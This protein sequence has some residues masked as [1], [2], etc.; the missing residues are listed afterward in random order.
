MAPDSTRDTD[1]TMADGPPTTQDRGPEVDRLLEDSALFGALDPHERRHLFE[2]GVRVAFAPGAVIVE[3]GQPGDSFFLVESG[4]VEVSTRASGSKLVLSRMSRGA[5]FG[6]GTAFS[7]KPRT[8]TVVALGPVEAVRFDDA[9][10][11]AL[12]DR[13]PAIREELQA[14]VLERA[15][16]TIEKTLKSRTSSAPEP[17]RG[18]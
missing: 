17:R 4:E 12:L 9:E 5:I 8:A 6:E 2:T 18:G 16:D 7:G 3:E 15:S 14:L 1:D 10:L 11:E 13:H